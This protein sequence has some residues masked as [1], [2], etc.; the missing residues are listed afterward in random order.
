MSSTIFS[1]SAIRYSNSGIQG[2]GENWIRLR[3][4]FGEKMATGSGKQ[5]P[6]MGIC[7][8]H[9]GGNDNPNSKYFT[10]EKKL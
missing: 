7:I 4:V 9:F 8:M 5:H 6:K 1:L 3:S 10:N 2:K